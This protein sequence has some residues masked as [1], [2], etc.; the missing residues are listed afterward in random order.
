[1]NTEIKNEDAN[2]ARRNFLRKSL[3]T[4]SV[5]AVGAI[6]L[7]KVFSGEKADD[8]KKVK[9]LTADGKVLETSTSNLKELKHTPVTDAESRK[10]IPGKKF[11]MVIDLAKCDGCGHCTVECNK[12]HHI[13]KS[14]EWIKVIEMQDSP[15]EAPYWFVKPC[16][17]CDNPPCTKVCPVDATFKREDGIVAIDN[18]RCIGCR[19]CMAACPYSARIFNWSE[20]LY[21]EYPKKSA[22]DTTVKE[23]SCCGGSGCDADSVESTTA[24]AERFFESKKGCVEKCDFCPHMARENKLPACVTGCGMDAIYF[25]DENEDAVTNKSGQ[26]V[27]LSQLLEDRAAYRYLEELGTKPRVYYLPPYNRQYAKPDMKGEKS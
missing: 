21:V 22:K 7:E 20:P 17:H 10:G 23:T 25:G 12:M 13:P 15:K 8:G 18:D 19:F 9:V 6:G 1:M 2:N 14:K 11:V 5:L 16:F 26:T 27:S 24:P 4:G 3:I